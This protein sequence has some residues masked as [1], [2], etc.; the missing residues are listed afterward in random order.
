MLAGRDLTGG[1][2][3]LGID[4]RGR[5]AAV[6]N[7]RDPAAHRPGARS[8]G[9]LILDYLAGDQAPLPFLQEVAATRDSYLPFN[10]LAGAAGTLGYF[11]SRGGPPRELAPGTYGLSNALLDTPWPKVASGRAALQEQVAADRIVPAL[12]FAVLAEN[13]CAP[14]DQL[15][16]TGVGRDWE[17][18]LSPRFIHTPEYG[19][20]SSTVLLIGR[21]G[22][23]RFSER[24]FGPGAPDRNCQFSFPTPV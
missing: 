13:T 3:W 17:R 22:L 24:S 21:D 19:T 18:Q 16:E 23:A 14:E 8:R 9:L 4:R 6:T 15:P 2:T 7:F 1:G 20:R 10:L 5:W 11:G 12:L